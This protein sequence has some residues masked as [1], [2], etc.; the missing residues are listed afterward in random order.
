MQTGMA[1]SVDSDQSAPLGE[2]SV[3]PDQTA[4]LGAVWSDLGLHC[5]IRS[6]CPKTY[7]TRAGVCKTYA[8][9][10]CLSPEIAVS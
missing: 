8:P 1:N 2:N 5:L 3:D 6:V 7:R 10:I 9:N 4:P